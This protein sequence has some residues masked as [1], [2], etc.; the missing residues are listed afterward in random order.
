MRL[1]ANR[2]LAHLGA[3]AENSGA[4]SVTGFPCADAGQIETQSYIWALATSR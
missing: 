1:G 2:D 3:A 4:P